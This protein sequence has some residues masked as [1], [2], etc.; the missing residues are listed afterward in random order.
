MQHDGT[1]EARRSVPMMRM[2][3]AI[4]RPQSILALAFSFEGQVVLPINR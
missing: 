1:E 3:E 2:P 4:S